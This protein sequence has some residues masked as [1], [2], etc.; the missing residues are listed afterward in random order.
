MG[1]TVADVA[2]F[3]NVIQG[4]HPFDHVSLPA[5]PIPD[6]LGD[7]RGLRVALAV[8]LGD[9]PVEPEVEANT[10]ALRRG[11]AHAPAPSSTR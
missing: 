3:H 6:D 4:Q 2:L 8:T 1:R 5:L 9:F 10:R 7:V 11:A